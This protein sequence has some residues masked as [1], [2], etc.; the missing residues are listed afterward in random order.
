MKAAPHSLDSGVAAEQRCEKP[1]V[2]SRME[3]NHNLGQTNV[4]DE[5]KGPPLLVA[6]ASLR[7]RFGVVEAVQGKWSKKGLVS[8]SSPRSTIYDWSVFNPGMYLYRINFT[9]YGCRRNQGLAPN[10]KR[11]HQSFCLP[12]VYVRVSPLHQHGCSS[13]ALT[14]VER[15]N[16]SY[17]DLV[18]H[19]VLLFLLPLNIN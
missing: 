9:M 15:M 14:N 10:I 13:F 17:L 18:H 5:S 3:K 2:R 7:A 19:S 16:R 8:G 11:S 1:T 6:S 4:S 12:T